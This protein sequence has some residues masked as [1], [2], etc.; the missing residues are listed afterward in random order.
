MQDCG[1]GGI[2]VRLDKYVKWIDRVVR[3]HRPAGER[4]VAATSGQPAGRPSPG[5]ALEPGDEKSHALLV[6]VTVYKNKAIPTLRG[7]ANDVDLMRSLLRTSFRFPD[8]N[9][10]TLSEERADK[11]PSAS[12]VREH[13]IRELKELERTADRGS[14]VVVYFSGHGSQQPDLVRPD[15]K[16]DG[17]SEIFLPSDTGNWSVESERVENA[18]IDFELRDLLGAVRAKGALVWAIIDSCHSGS[19]VRGVSDVT[20]RLIEDPRQ[21]FNVPG[22]AYKKALERIDPNRGQTELSRTPLAQPGLVALYASMPDEP[23]YEC[24]LPDRPSLGQQRK[25]YGIFTWLLSQAIGEMARVPDPDMTYDELARRID[26]KLGQLGKTFPHPAAEGQDRHRVILG[27]RQ[28]R[29]PIVLSRYRDELSEGKDEWK[30]NAGLLHGLEVGSVLA[31]YPLDRPAQDGPVGYVKIVRF[32]DPQQSVVEPAPF[33]GRTPP[34]PLAENAFC[35]VAFVAVGDLRL[36]VGVADTTARGKPI[37]LADV[38]ELAGRL[39][40]LAAEPDSVI[41]VVETRDADWLIRSEGAAIVMIRKEG[42]K[43]PLRL[44]TGSDDAADELEIRLRKVARVEL[45]KQL[46]RFQPS[47]QSIS[48]GR[49]VAFDMDLMQYDSPGAEGRQVQWSNTGVELRP[50]SEIALRLTNR[51]SFQTDVTVLHI[52][53]GY[54]IHSIFPEGPFDSR[55]RLKPP[56]EM[57]PIITDHLKVKA[58]GEG[59]HYFLVF[60]LKAHGTKSANLS[61]LEQDDLRGVNKEVIGPA[62]AQ[63]ELWR[64]IE[65]TYG[66]KR[67]GDLGSGL[68]K[69]SLDEQVVRLYHWEIKP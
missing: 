25:Q 56:G 24:P 61:M 47:P 29:T 43:Y 14:R 15:P 34:Y 20:L 66:V 19:I 1:D 9:I 63:T 38:T 32:V 11:D 60:A 50:G 7:P 18:I 28:R 31:V 40:R 10:V 69:A 62:L 44:K 13:I 45:L 36:N 4:A 17:L 51:S 59:S 12:P 54:G 37:P 16:P 2:Y 33:K 48:E 41:R 39:S 53:E 57:K 21:A 65:R 52:D 35:D 67:D 49:A 6:G 26:M 23:T 42:M 30:I 46:Q 8:K 55:N 64:L 27:V 3:A 5:A 58:R 22:A 68:E